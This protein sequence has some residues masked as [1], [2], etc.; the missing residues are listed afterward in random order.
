MSCFANSCSL[1]NRP[2]PSFPTRRSSDLPVSGQRLR[3]SA[4]LTQRNVSRAFAAFAPLHAACLQ[5]VRLAG[6]LRAVQPHACRGCVERARNEGIDSG[7]GAACQ[8]TR[9]D[10]AVAQ[11]NPQRNLCGSHASP[12]RARL[13]A[14][15][16]REYVI[17]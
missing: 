3:I 15:A 16:L 13:A 1:T 11:A 9:D 14:L 10:R 7:L 17:T 2:L 4:E 12:R 6:A 5:Q 8:V